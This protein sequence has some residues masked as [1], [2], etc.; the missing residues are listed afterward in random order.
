MNTRPCRCCIQG[1]QVQC[2][3]KPTG[4]VRQAIS[5]IQIR[6]TNPTW[7]SQL[8]ISP[9]RAFVMS[10]GRLI[11]DAPGDMEMHEHRLQKLQGDSH[12][13]PC[14]YGRCYHRYHRY[15]CE[16]FNGVTTRHSSQRS[17]NATLTHNTTLIAAIANSN[18]THKIL[19]SFLR[20]LFSL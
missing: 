4:L 2:P 14:A 9:G 20:L 8:K 10:I 12:I 1:S 18:F 11:H 15:Q 3:R 16:E 17:E 19:N 13:P 5:A 7:S 6:C